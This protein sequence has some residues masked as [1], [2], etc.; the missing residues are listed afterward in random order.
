MEQK[1]DTQGFENNIEFGKYA[2]TVSIIR[3]KYAQFYI[4]IRKINAFILASFWNS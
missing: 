3:K 1:N 4:S 2:L